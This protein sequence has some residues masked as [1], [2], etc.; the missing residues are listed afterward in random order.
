M[1]DVGLGLKFPFLA[2]CYVEEQI[3]SRKAREEKKS[4]H[5]CKIGPF[6]CGKRKE[7]VNGHYYVLVERDTLP[8]KFLV[9]DE[10]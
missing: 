2:V 8:S 7:N 4:H 5:R 10:S 9:S 6:F 3:G 1:D